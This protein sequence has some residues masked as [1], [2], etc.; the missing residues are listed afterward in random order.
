MKNENMKLMY[1]EPMTT[2]SV[3]ESEGFI[4][5]SVHCARK[6]IE[7]DQTVALPSQKI[8]FDGDDIYSSSIN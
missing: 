3:V 8:T 5:A 7:V 4:C 1:A 6:V 2:I